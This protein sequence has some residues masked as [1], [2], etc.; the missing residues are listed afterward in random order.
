MKI[1]ELARNMLKYPS[2]KKGVKILD[3][4]LTIVVAIFALGSVFLFILDNASEAGV[5]VP[6]H[7][8]DTYNNLSRKQANLNTT[9][10]EL[11]DSVEDVTEAESAAAVAWNGFKG[12][13]ELF[14][15]PL[16][17]LDTG[18]ESLTLGL[19]FVDFIPGIALAAI[20]LGITI[21]IV[22]AILRFFTQ[23]GND[24]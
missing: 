23:R 8:N 3:V 15:L 14:K 16:Q 18:L 4:M 17:L 7:Y 20:T 12:M 9:A 24:V 5:T 11:R 22:F 10:Y 1:N 19:S 21:I 6:A 13:L 2:E